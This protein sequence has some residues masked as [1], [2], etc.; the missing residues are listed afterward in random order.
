[1]TFNDEE[2]GLV[3]RGSSIFRQFFYNHVV[4]DNNMHLHERAPKLGLANFEVI[5]LYFT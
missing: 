4:S 2:G 1:M 3:R 5:E